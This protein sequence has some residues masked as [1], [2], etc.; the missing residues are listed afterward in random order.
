MITEDLHV[1]T[2][3]CDGANTPREMVEAALR[4]G[5]KRIGFSGHSHTAIDE[6]YCMAFGAEEYRREIA[7]L[8]EEYRGKIDVLCGVEQ[9]YYSDDT[10]DGYDFVI[11]SVHYIKAG[12]TYIPVDDTAEKLSEGAE[13]FNGDV[14]ALVEAYYATVADVVNKT[15]CDIIGH[16][17]LITKFSERTPLF[18]TSHPRYVAAWQSA[19]DALL[20]TGKVFEINTGAISRGYRTSPYPS[21][22]ICRYLASRGAVFRLSGDSHRADT[23]CFDFDQWG[24]FNFE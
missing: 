21:A 24:N 13:L 2:T 19:A 4:K 1:H 12:E 10:T 20:R 7:R 9:D 3:F 15:N 11:G 16:F 22:E 8:K 6:S 14:Y 18:N 17:D 5:L 23:L